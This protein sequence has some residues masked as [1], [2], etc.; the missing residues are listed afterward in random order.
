MRDLRGANAIVTGASRGLGV[1]ITH[2][3][4]D[5]GVNLVIAARSAEGL[6]KVRGDVAA[7]GVK[8]VSVP[9][10]VTELG[11]LEN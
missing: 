7:N 10:D 4:A 2:A 1:L 9:T 8:V 11:Q 3:L 5:E 6:E